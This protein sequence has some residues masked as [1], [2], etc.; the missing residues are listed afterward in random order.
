LVSNGAAIFV[1]IFPVTQSSGYGDTMAVPSIPTHHVWGN[2]MTPK[3]GDVLIRGD[4]NGGY[5]V[6]D[7]LTFK[8]LS[9]THASTVDAAL[10]IARMQGGRIW[11]QAVDHRGRPL[12]EPLP[13]QPV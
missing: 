9:E 12:S 3:F 4:I 10:V 6:V 5:E 1:G 11:Q 13:L 7:A 8:R 2:A